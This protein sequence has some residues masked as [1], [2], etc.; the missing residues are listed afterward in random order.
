VIKGLGDIN[1]Q[2]KGK[3]DAYLYGDLAPLVPLD[4]KEA[5]LPYLM[6]EVSGFGSFTIKGSGS[7]D[8]LAKAPAGTYQAPGIPVKDGVRLPYRINVTGDDVTVEIA[9]LG[10]FS[11]KLV[12]F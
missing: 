4:E 8:M 3:A 7:L 1:W 11:G 5:K 9:N 2:G 12:K 6:E 10:E